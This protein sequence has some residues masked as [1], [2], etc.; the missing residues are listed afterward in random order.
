MA[1]LE[2]RVGAPL[3]HRTTRSIRLS[4]VGERYA[5]ACRR[6]L[7]ELLEVDILAEGEGSAPRGTLTLTAPVMSGEEILRPI[8]DAFLTL[9]QRYR[10]SFICS[11][12]RSI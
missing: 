9:F 10:R 12:G 4:E 3:L 7:A 2:D 5:G 6:V 11:T 1:F 8:L